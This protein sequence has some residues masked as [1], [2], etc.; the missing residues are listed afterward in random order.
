MYVGPSYTK[1]CELRILQLQETTTTNKQVGEEKLVSD[2][3]GAEGVGLAIVLGL[4]VNTQHNNKPARR[5]S[6]FPALWLACN[7]E[8]ERK[9][10]M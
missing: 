6:R 4:I 10:E 3:A 9:R 1:P 2:G 5:R 7:A 8:R